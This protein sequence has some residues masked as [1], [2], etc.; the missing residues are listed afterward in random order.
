MQIEDGKF[1]N[2]NGHAAR[3]RKR[4]LVEER[5]KTWRKPSKVN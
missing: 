1:R 2:S 3:T 4:F 5:R